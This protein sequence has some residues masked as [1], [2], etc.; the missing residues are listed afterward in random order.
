[1]V[2]H[3]S[4]TNA[5][6]DV[7]RLHNLTDDETGAIVYYTTDATKFGGKREDSPYF[8]LNNTLAFRKDKELQDWKPFLH[9]LLSG[10]Q[11]LPNFTGTV[12]RA[13]DK[14]LSS[15]SK[16]YRAGSQVVWVAFTSTTKVRSKLES[17]KNLYFFFFFED[18]ML[19]F[20]GQTEGTWMILSVCEGKDISSFSVYP[21][22][23]EILLLPNSIFS[24]ESTFTENQKRLGM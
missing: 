12:Y 3:M 18:T 9:F 2:T 11:K 13:L 7:Q 19:A 5:V 15:L 24:V 4:S 22:E 8:K 10:L 23:S 14:S 16:Q 21:N 17:V 20:S 1:M 6:N